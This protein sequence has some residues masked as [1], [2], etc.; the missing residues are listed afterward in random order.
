MKNQDRELID[1]LGA[2]A[3]RQE[4]EIRALHKLCVEL[5]M[6][7]TGR[8]F[9]YCENALLESSKS[10]HHDALV[11]LEEQSPELAAR[12]DRRGEGHV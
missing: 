7:V 2:I 4:G 8:P 1:C 3:Y 6:K 9:D 11:R 12:F 5:M 10:E